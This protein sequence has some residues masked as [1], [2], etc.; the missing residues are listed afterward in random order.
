MPITEL[1]TVASG[2][3]M[4]VNLSLSTGPSPQTIL[5]AP[6]QLELESAS[7]ETLFGEE[8]DA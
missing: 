1:I 5:P 6:L 3:I 7:T 2:G 8:I 4:W